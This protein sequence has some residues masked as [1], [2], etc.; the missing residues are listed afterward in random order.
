MVDMWHV[1][2]YHAWAAGF[3]MRGGVPWS[4]RAQAGDGQEE[5]KPGR[6]LLQMVESI[7]K[8]PWA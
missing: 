4:S 2:L 5:E 3:C 1:W 7:S 8:S 6:A